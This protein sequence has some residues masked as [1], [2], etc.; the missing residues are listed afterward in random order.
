MTT[1]QQEVLEQSI[2]IWETA[3]AEQVEIATAQGREQALADGVVFTGISATDQQFF[4][5]LY[6]QEAAAN[7]ASA[8]ARYG[9]DA[10]T[11]FNV[12]RTSVAPDSGVRCMEGV[13]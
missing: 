11:V 12:A 6:I 13:F 4:D 8:S 7:A 1:A 3:L 9:L 2:G 5:E 10:L